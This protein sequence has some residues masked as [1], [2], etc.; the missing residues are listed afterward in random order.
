V[1][2]LVRPRRVGRGHADLRARVSGRVEGFDD[3]DLMGHVWCGDTVPR[4]GRPAAIR[5][6]SRAYRGTNQVELVELGS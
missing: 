3:G 2:A 4:G 5:S 1:R 6:S